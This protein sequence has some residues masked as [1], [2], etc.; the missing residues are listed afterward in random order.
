MKFVIRAETRLSMEELA[1]LMIDAFTPQDIWDLICEID[2]Q[3][4]DDLIKA[5]HQASDEFLTGEDGVQTV[6]KLKDAVL[7]LQADLEEARSV[8]AGFLDGDE[9]ERAIAFLERLH[10]DEQENTND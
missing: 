1:K 7:K 4:D 2:K 8:I 3:I 10:N 9:E 6:G 5:I